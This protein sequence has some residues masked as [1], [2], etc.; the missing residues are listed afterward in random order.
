VTASLA[1]GQPTIAHDETM[2]QVRKI[3]ADKRAN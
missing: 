2:S 3:I 1:D